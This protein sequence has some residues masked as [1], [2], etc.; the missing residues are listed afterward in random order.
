MRV[1]QLRSDFADRSRG[2]VAYLPAKGYALS[3]IES[4]DSRC[5]TFD[6][7]PGDSIYR[8]MLPNPSLDRLAATKFVSGPVLRELLSIPLS[9]F[10]WAEIYP[11]LQ[12]AKIERAEDGRA[13]I[14]AQGDYLIIDRQSGQVDFRSLDLGFW[15][16]TQKFPKFSS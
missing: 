9:E 6:R 2:L 14:N 11:S 16:E 12:E 5:W 15:P 10:Q 3:V 13:W 8:I 1:F 4:L 7:V